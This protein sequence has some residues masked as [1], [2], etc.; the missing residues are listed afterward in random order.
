M[1]TNNPQYINLVK[2]FSNYLVEKNASHSTIKNYISDTKY[3]VEWLET[4]RS[5][6]LNPSTLYEELI[7]LDKN[8]TLTYIKHMTVMG[9]NLKT[10]AR[11]LASL[12]K[13]SQFLLSSG[14]TNFDFSAGYRN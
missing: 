4:I 6:Q 8:D 10:I 14:L 2:E 3:F 1:S 12:K 7:S 11:R 5:S 9:A 13:L